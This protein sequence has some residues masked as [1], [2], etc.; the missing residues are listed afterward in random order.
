MF[1][2]DNFPISDIWLSILITMFNLNTAYRPG[3]QK[4]KKKKITLCSYF[5]V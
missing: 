4:K 3:E 5:D 2:I 1:G